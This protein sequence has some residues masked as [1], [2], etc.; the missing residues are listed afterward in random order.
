[1]NRVK[2]FCHRKDV[3]F[4]PKRYFIDVMSAMALGLFAS[5]LI[6]T[7]LK[8]LGQQL[9][10]D[11]LVEAGNQATAMMGPAIGV[12]VAW[13]LKA[14]GLV[15]FASTVTGMVGATLGGPA[16]FIAAVIGA[17]GKLII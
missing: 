6:G 15:L 1:M 2:A 9:S 8:T 14:P 11:F 12:A 5:L 4:S 3:V 10:I 16:A 17:D 7:I 13:S